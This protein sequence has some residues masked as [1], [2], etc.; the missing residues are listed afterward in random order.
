MS[1]TRNL[2]LPL[3]AAAQAQKHVT[4]N[5]A[6]SL[7][8][9]LVQ[10]ACLDKDL[11]NP[12][13][14]PAE[15]DRYLVAAAEPGG[16]W[17]AL[18]GQIALFQD[19]AWTGIAPRPG[20][21]A[22]LVDEADLYTFTGTGWTS[23]RS[24][25]TVLQNLARLGINTV[26]DTGNRLAVKAEGAL[27]SWDETT[28]GSGS[29]RLTVNKQD[30]GKDAGLVFQTGFSTR[31]LLGTL[32]SDAFGLKM[33][34]DGA[35]FVQAL[36]AR[37]DTGWLTVN[38]PGPALAPLH[39]VNN[40]NGD[41]TNNALFFENYGN[42]TGGTF[43]PVVVIKTAVARGSAGAP[44][45]ILKGDRFFGFFGSGFHAGGAYSGN[46]VAFNGG[47][48]EDFT[49]GAWGTYLDFQTTPLGGTARRS[50]VKVRAN[51]TLE[52]QPQASP[53]SAGTAAGQLVFDSTA[54]AFKGHD[55][56]RWT[57]LTNQPCFAATA[58]SDTYLSAGTWT[59][60][61]FNA[62]DSNDQ[63]VFHTDDKRFV[64]P[65]GGLYRFGATLGFKRNGSSAP[66]AF[67]IRAYRNGSPS[68]RGRGAATGS[69]V[70][71]VTAIA[72]DTVL[73]LDAG[74][75]V[76]IFARLSGADGYAAAAESLFAGLQIAAR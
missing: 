70:D 10:I 57:R 67:E 76:E 62:T 43:G 14:A 47:A 5:E 27:F 35:R 42:D 16:A 29:T 45:P 22:Y 69:L 53:P 37:A 18:S 74:D 68:G 21:L 71:G 3:I 39:I 50:A 65:E 36:S 23:F 40:A 19:G 38:G 30:A 11:T 1:T 59:K 32:G 26:A 51:G 73:K 6:L 33:S 44:Q 54:G 61:A 52:L 49:A 60:I 28:P 2:A 46:A 64:A 4:H 72:L 15:G 9:A 55:G 31:A 8:D 12:P 24:T 7:L 56:T 41:P 48:D 34:P 75:T 25:L 20:W 58:S 63:G 66:S 17:A 13:A